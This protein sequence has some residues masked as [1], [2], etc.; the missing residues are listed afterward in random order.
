MCSSD[1]FV[2]VS[3]CGA[4]QNPN[5]VT[6]GGVVLTQVTANGSQS[7][8]RT[9]TYYGKAT[10]SGSRVSVFWAGQHP[11]AAVIAVYKS[12]AVGNTVIV[13]SSSAASVSQ[14]TSSTPGTTLSPTPSN[15]CALCVVGVENGQ[16][17]ILTSPTGFTLS[18]EGYTGQN[19]NPVDCAQNCYVLDIPL[20]TTISSSV[21]LVGACNNNVAMLLIGKP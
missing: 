1:L 17:T 2:A 4:N 15:C 14:N 10:T 8:V 18:D 21:T 19:Q 5:S 12:P 9:T 3:T 6:A 16:G 11:S 13:G 20:S 7:H